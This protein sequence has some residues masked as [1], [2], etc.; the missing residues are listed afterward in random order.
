MFHFQTLTYIHV[1]DKCNQNWFAVASILEDTLKT[2][3][4]GF[5]S[6]KEAF[7]RS[8]NAGCYHCSYLILSLSDLGK[9]TGITISRYDFSDPQAGKDVCDRRIATVKSHMRRF[10]NEGNDIKSAS[11]MKSAIDSYGG[12]KGCQSAVARIQESC[13]TMTKHSMTG[14]QSLNNF[15]FESTGLR[16]WKAY[17]VGPGKL[18]TH[19]QL[20]R[21]GTPQGPTRLIILIT[22]N[23]PRLQRSREITAVVEGQSGSAGDTRQATV[24]EDQPDPSLP[25]LT[26]EPD[27]QFPC[28][29]EGCIKTYQSFQ[30]LQKHLDVGKH[31][32]KLERES[33]YDTIKKKWAETCKEVSGSYVHHAATA[34]SSSSVAASAHNP[35]SLGWAL[36]ATRKSVRFTENIKVYLK[37]KFMEGEETGRKAN[38]S[39]VASKIKTLRTATGEKM[40][41]KDE[42]LV[43]NQVARYFSRLSTLYRSGRLELDLASLG[44]TQ[45]EEEDYVT[46]GEEIST[47]LEIRR[48]LEL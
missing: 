18:I 32:V 44:V 16:V 35:V 10:I 37:Q 31:L 14:I 8:D 23:E 47:R 11:D 1:F 40:F 39:D 29:E 9:R 17:G 15:S 42:W 4:T 22:F 36:K 2:L 34:S 6:L 43:A 13:Q 26:K 46:E 33:N 25:Q 41:A 27:V 28:P 45:D 48:E 19:A 3:K 30:S 5:P 12:V 21:F 20:K 7:L 24:T 38:P